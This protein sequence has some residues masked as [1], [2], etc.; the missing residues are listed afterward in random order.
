MP[1]SR[2]IVAYS[3]KSLDTLVSSACQ[4]GWKCMGRPR[5]HG[6][7]HRQVIIREEVENNGRTED[8]T[9]DL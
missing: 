5:L 3:E 7:E 6:T 2:T 9:R 4:C 1:Q 8:T